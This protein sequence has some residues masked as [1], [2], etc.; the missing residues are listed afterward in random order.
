MEQFKLLIHVYDSLVWIGDYNL[1]EL[2]NIV[3]RTLNFIMRT[4]SSQKRAI[5][6]YWLW[7]FMLVASDISYVSFDIS[8]VRLSIQLTIEEVQPTNRLMRISGFFS[9]F[10]WMTSQ[11]VYSLRH[12][13]FEI[14]HYNQTTNGFITQQCI[15]IVSTDETAAMDFCLILNGM[16]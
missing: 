9:L 3:K 8:L 11:N 13:M 7:Y 15:C 10:F 12:L 5:V 16:F 14:M 2:F 6:I 1:I 4:E